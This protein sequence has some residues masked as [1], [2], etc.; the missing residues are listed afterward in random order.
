MTGTR[1]CWTC[2]KAKWHRLGADG[3]HDGW[4]GAGISKVRTRENSE[5]CSAHAAKMPVTSNAA[6]QAAYRE[7]LRSQ[8]LET[9]TV[10]VP[11]VEAGSVRALC[12]RLCSDRDLTVGP[13]RRLSN[14]QL[15]RVR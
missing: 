13:L 4:C 8:G 7:R 6:R 9:L 11:K 3:W 12:D 1:T 14:G 2:S 15:V 5:A 10:K